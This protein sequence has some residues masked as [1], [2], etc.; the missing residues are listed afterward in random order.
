MQLKKFIG[1]NVFE[2]ENRQIHQS[3]LN[4]DLIKV[5]CQINREM[6]L[7]HPLYAPK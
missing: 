2:R 3:N 7:Y 1:T 5:K 4:I 6:K